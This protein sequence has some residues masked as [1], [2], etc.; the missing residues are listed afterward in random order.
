MPLHRVTV[1]TASTLA[2]VALLLF[3]KPHHT[4]PPDVTARPPATPPSQ[5]PSTAPSGNGR[6][7]G[8][9]IDTPYGPVQVAA[10]LAHGRLTAVTVL[11]VPRGTGRDQEIAS[12]SL[13]RLTREALGAQSARIDAVS[14]ASYTSAGY[15]NSLQSALDQAHG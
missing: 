4:A 8:S 10:T 3:L 15:I 5:H 6:F 2:G 1:T 12:Y 14:G 9:I 11:Q 7:T 13:P